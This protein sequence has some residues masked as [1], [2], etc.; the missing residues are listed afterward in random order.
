MFINMGIAFPQIKVTQTTIID[1]FAKY[2]T[3][4]ILHIRYIFKPGVRLPQAGAPGF[5]KS[6][7]FRQSMHVCV[8]PRGRK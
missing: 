5:L 7:S 6:L 4:I 2:L 3:P 1:R 8:H